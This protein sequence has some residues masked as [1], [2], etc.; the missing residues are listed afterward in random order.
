M[1]LVTISVGKKKNPLNNL[2]GHYL[3][4]LRLLLFKI[5]L[6][7]TKGTKFIFI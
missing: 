1:Q 2:K 4:Y 7:R 3:G 6:D 5:E